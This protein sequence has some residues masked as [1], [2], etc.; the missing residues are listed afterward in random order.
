MS[1]LPINKKAK[2]VYAELLNLAPYKDPR[3]VAMSLSQQ[4]GKYKPVPGL[5]GLL[6]SETIRHD[7]RTSGSRNQL[8]RIVLPRTAQGKKFRKLR[9]TRQRKQKRGSGTR[10]ATNRR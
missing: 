7:L 3:Y 8:S 10:R 2:R 5:E 6:R 1:G 4:H 9:K